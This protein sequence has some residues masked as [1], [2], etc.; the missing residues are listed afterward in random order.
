VVDTSPPDRSSGYP[1]G[2]VDYNNGEVIAGLSTNENAV[3]K[4]S[5]VADTSFTAMND[6][7]SSGQISHEFKVQ[8][9][10]MGKTYEFFV[11]CMDEVGNVNSD[12]YIIKFN[13][14]E[15]VIKEVPE[16]QC[17]K[18]GTVTSLRDGATDFSFSND[19]GQTWNYKPVADMTGMD[20]NVTNI[21]LIDVR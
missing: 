13:I 9:V 21:R 8:D 12:D 1:D 4:Y 17:Y 10:V 3:C 19:N 7:Y 15:V 20:C 2:P 14:A 11:K 18:V 5:N 16:C 6:M